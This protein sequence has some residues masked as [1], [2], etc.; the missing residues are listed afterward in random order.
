MVE[1]GAGIATGNSRLKL[2]MADTVV[3]AVGQA[4]LQEEAMAYYG[5]APEFHAIGDCVS[6]KNIQ[7]ATS[8]A[9]LIALSI[10]TE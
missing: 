3:F 4:P 2:I 8:S 7:A 6:A 9:Y 1:C 5:C 10:G